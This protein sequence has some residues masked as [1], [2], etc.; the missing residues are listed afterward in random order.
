MNIKII[1]LIALT[2]ILLTGNIS[3]A[4]SLVSAKDWKP[5][6]VKN[7]QVS[8][9]YLPLIGTKYTDYNSTYKPSS[10]P[11]E[12]GEVVLTTAHS[13]DLSKVKIFIPPGTTGFSV[14]VQNYFGPEEAKAAAK[15]MEVPISNKDDIKPSNYDTR[16]TL[17]RLFNKEELQFYSPG[18]SGSLSIANSENTDTFKTT[19]GGYI[20][21]NFLSLP[22]GK[23]LRLQTRVTVEQTCYNN[24]YSKGKWDQNGNPSEYD[25]HECDNVNVNNKLTAEQSRLVVLKNGMKGFINE[26]KNNPQKVFAELKRNNFTLDEIAYILD[27][28]KD[29]VDQYFKKAGL[30]YDEKYTK[31]NINNTTSA[32]TLQKPS[33]EAIKMFVE[34]NIN[35]PKAIHDAAK[36]YNLT[37][38]DLAKALG[39][40]QEQV[41]KYF[42]QAGLPPLK[43]SNEAIKSFIEQNINN[44][45]TIHDAAKAYNLS[46]DDLAKVT[47]LPREQV[48]DYFKKAGLKL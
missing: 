9:V 38:A 3:F 15:F 35:N 10:L 43:P 42:T 45:K 7:N 29:T 39:F 36:A 30:V 14:S 16:Q 44:P 12:N 31:E 17:R 23:I 20:Y 2:S 41:T 32:T 11:V 47:K 22:G 24:W 26:N 4:Q 6:E 34:K 27:T 48:I 5:I 33:N 18:G 46:V 1:K 28:D 13:G 21:L 25:V 19:T 8:N 37:T 40:S